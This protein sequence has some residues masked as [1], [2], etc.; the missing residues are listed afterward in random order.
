[1][2]ALALLCLAV[3]KPMRRCR[4]LTQTRSAL[5]LELIAA[6]D[7]GGT[8]AG[9]MAA[10]AC[11]FPVMWLRHRK[12]VSFFGGPVDVFGAP[13]DSP[14]LH[15][16]HLHVIDGA[17]GVDF[18]VFETHGDFTRGDG[19]AWNATLKAGTCF[20][21]D[22]MPDLTNEYRDPHGAYVATAEVNDRVGKG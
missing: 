1:M 19:L 15:V 9:E 16:H 18:H 8:L 7:G 5:E 21:Y 13:I 22:G 11:E 4:L 10:H 2:R 12:I 3:G 6:D 20:V 14:P 17:D